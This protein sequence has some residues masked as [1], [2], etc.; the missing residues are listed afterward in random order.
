M[1]QDYGNRRLG[2]PPGL[3]DSP[4]RDRE[5]NGGIVERVRVPAAPEASEQLF[6]IGTG[7]SLNDSD[8]LQD[9][10]GIKPVRVMPRDF[11]HETGSDEEKRLKA[12]IPFSKPITGSNM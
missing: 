7:L 4:N 12:G 9:A 6:P 5:T 3:Y 2:G 1:A 8:N 10:L 11:N